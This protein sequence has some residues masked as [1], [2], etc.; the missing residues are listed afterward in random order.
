MKSIRYKKDISSFDK[1]QQQQK[2]KTR[3]SK[4]KQ[5]IR[6]VENL[7]AYLESI[8]GGGGMIIPNVGVLD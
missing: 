1:E 6:V 8:K 2:P 4:K 3:E 7:H 5:K